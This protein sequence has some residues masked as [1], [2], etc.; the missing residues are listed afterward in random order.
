MKYTVTSE[1]VDTAAR[2]GVLSTSRGD[3]KT[4]VFMPVATRGAI[5]ALTSRD[6]EEIGF[7]IILAN[8]YH[9]YIRPGVELLQKAGGLHSFMNHPGPIL[10][11]SGGFQVFSLSDLC[12]VRSAGVEFRSHLDGSRH[13]FAPEKVL[14]IQKVIGSDIMMVLDQCTHYPVSEG[15]SR[16]AMERTLNWA[17]HSRKYWNENFD[18]DVQSLFAIVQ[19]SVFPDQRQESA[20]RLVEMDF[21]GYAIGGLSVGEPLNLYR[22]LTDVTLH[23]LPVNK[24]RYMMGVGS[25]MEILYAIGCGVDMFDCVMPT[26]IARNGTLYTSAGRVTIK[27]ARYE[28]DFTPLDEKCSC[29]VCRNFTKA[30]LRH[31]F[32]MD[33]IAALIYNTYHN[34]WFMKTFMEEIRVSIETGSFRET[35][36]K[37][38]SLYP[39]T[40]P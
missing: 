7:D 37:W 26:R 24:P 31:L 11:D 2:T 16:D 9:L 40:R 21:P 20:Q 35:V 4:P 30:Y 29:Y 6:V 10:T 15:E 3:I 25:P 36:R 1:S 8:T 5:R 19:G 32:R 27:A 34:L 23:Y 39:A 33:E 12:K 28:N 38:D 14:D 17:E 13:F 18:T 22:E